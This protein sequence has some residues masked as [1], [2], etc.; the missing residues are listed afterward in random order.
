MTKHMSPLGIHI[1]KHMSPLGIPLDAHVSTRAFKGTRDHQGNAWALLQRKDSRDAWSPGERLSTVAAQGFTGL[2][3]SPPG[4]QTRSLEGTRGRYYPTAIREH[5]QYFSQESHN[6]H[7]RITDAFHKN[8][9]IISSVLTRISQVH[10]TE[11]S[12]NNF[13]FSCEN[14]RIRMS[15]W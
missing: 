3:R 2:P 9:T 14:T 4:F 12:S 5:T 15:H 7:T 11:S 10:N 6:K 8:H 1:T 13:R